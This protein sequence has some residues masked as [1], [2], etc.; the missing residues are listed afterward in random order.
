MKPLSIQQ[1]RQA[2]GGTPLSAVPKDAPD[3][4][5]VCTNSKQIE[6]GS[7]FIALRGERHDAHA[8]LPEA[9][10][11]GAVAALVERPPDSEISSRSPF[12]AE[13]PPRVKLRGS[14]GALPAPTFSFMASR[15]RSNQIA[16]LG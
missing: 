4:T 6:P 2:V 9:A 12:G 3:V 13:A 7:L 10:R 11:G 15:V 14:A 5:A 8:F 1:V 16:A